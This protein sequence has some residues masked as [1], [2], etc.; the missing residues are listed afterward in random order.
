[1]VN[2]ERREFDLLLEE[3]VTEKKEKECECRRCTIQ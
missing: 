1:M 3:D 2:C